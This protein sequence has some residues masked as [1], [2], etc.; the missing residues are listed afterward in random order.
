MADALAKAAKQDVGYCL[1]VSVTQAQFPTMLAAI[2]PLSPG[3]CVLPA[4]C[5]RSIRIPA[6]MV[7]CC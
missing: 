2:A 5:I 6:W 3:V 4:G 7:N 1:C